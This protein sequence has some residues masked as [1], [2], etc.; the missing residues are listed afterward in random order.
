ME[1]QQPRINWFRLAT[2]ARQ[3]EADSQPQ[4]EPAQQ[5]QAPPATVTRQPTQPVVRAPVVPLPVA[6]PRATTPSVT[7]PAS[8]PTMQQP[9]VAPPTVQPAQP[10]R[11]PPTP[12]PVQPAQPDRRSPTPPPVQP[13]QPDRR[14][15]TPPPAQPD[16]ILPTP[17]AVQPAQPDRRPPTPPPVQPAQPD[18]RPVT[19]PQQD[20][21]K[22]DVPTSNGVSK[23]LSALSPPPSPKFI[24]T[25]TPTPPP[26]SRVTL[27]SQVP[28]TSI[29]KTT[30][31]EAETEPPLVQFQLKSKATQEEGGDKVNGNGGVYN[32]TNTAK[33]ISGNADTSAKMNGA[34]YN[35]GNN[36]IR[37]GGNGKNTSSDSN[38]GNMNHEPKRKSQNMKVINIAGKNIGALME[39][40]HNVHGDGRNNTLHKGN[41][42]TGGSPAH[43]SKSTTRSKPTTPLVNNNVQSINNSLLFNSSCTQKSPGVH[44]TFKFREQKGKARK[45]RPSHD[46]T[47]S[48]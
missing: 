43:G 40:G 22:S 44:A 17:P 16:R 35:D 24:M 39:F 26:S 2:I 36:K 33:S 29:S 42:P 28:P 11:R 30:N 14:P 12:Q 18:R 6:Q 13:A 41:S 37:N 23:S 21:P 1:S 45:P 19:P 46:S 9:V 38:Q 3:A 47:S 10:D 15:P 34:R 31:P 7:Q 5:A 25:S 4:P 8:Q 48:K 20:I 32:N 27:P